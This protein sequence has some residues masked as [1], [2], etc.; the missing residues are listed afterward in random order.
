MVYDLFFT[1]LVLFLSAP[2]VDDAEVY[3]GPLAD[4]IG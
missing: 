3:G 4:P 1:V 2:S